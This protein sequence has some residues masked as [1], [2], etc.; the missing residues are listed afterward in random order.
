MPE[1]RFVVQSGRKLSHREQQISSSQTK[2]HAARVAHQRRVVRVQEAS[3]LTVAKRICVTEYQDEGREQDS[4]LQ[5][6][7]E[8][9]SLMLYK[10]NSDPFGAAVATEVTPR[11]NQIL[12]FLQD[13]YIPNTYPGS[14]SWVRSFTCGRFFK[15]QAR[16]M[17]SEA[18]AFCET[19]PYLTMLASNSGSQALERE[20]MSTQL[21]IIQKTRQAVSSNSE[22]NQQHLLLFTKSL[23]GAAMIEQDMRAA[24]SHARVLSHLLQR[25]LDAGTWRSLPVDLVTNCLFFILNHSQ[26][27]LRKSVLEI[28]TWADLYIQHAARPV[29]EYLAPLH[30]WFDNRLDPCLSNSHLRQDYRAMY[31]TVWLWSQETR[32]S[33]AISQDALNQY[34]GLQHN[35][36]SIRLVNH[37]VHFTDQLSRATSLGMPPR[38]EAHLVCQAILALSLL[39]FLATFVGNPKMGTRYIWRKH[40]M[41]L[42]RLQLLLMSRLRDGGLLLGEGEFG[43]EYRHA[44]LWAYWAGAT[45]EHREREADTNPVHGWFN[46]RFAKQC[47]VMGL[48]SWEQVETVLNGFALARLAQPPGSTWVGVL[49]VETWPSKDSNRFN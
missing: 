1:Y 25:H 7:H 8:S 19:L 39:A 43:F 14:P 45:W 23:F 29:V 17:L 11:I 33:P 22:A 24:S 32:P 16:L 13:T 47:Q 9:T 21:Q 12:T 26:M 2:A 38:R 48:K 35:V 15:D 34:C 28:D 4:R 3:A 46:T 40:G 18:P 27:M 37:F 6:Q 41:F 49:L 31:E 36:V 42:T 44:L 20:A 5:D 10:G 30:S